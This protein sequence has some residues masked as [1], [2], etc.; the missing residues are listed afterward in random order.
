MWHIY[1]TL[2]VS[3]KRTIGNSTWTISTVH[4][5]ICIYIIC[6]STCSL[7]V[8]MCVYARIYV[9]TIAPISQRTELDR[10]PLCILYIIHCLEMYQ[11][12]LFSS[13]TTKNNLVSQL[14][15]KGLKSSKAREKRN[16]P[17]NRSITMVFFSLKDF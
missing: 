8:Y 13:H 1:R 14:E 4:V 16:L 3:I 15:F 5:Y 9:R 10:F 11:S 12:F 2:S 6:I 17:F 7:Y